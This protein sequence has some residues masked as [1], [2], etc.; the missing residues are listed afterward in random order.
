MNG[1]GSPAMLCGSVPQRLAL[2]AAAPPTHKA[3]RFAVSEPSKNMEQKTEN[4]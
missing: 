3:P 1:S 4:S 2:L